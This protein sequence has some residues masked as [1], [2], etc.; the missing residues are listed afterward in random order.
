MY[1]KTG[2]SM[3]DCYFAR[4]IAINQHITQIPMHEHLLRHEIENGRLLE[5]A[6]R[7][8]NPENLLRRLFETRDEV[9]IEWRS[10]E[11]RGWSHCAVGERCRTECFGAADLLDGEGGESPVYDAI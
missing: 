9:R 7:A 1:L 8:T 10:H 3:L 2:N 11:V 6:I 5:A 4:H